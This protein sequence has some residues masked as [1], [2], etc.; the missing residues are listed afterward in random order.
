VL[1]IEGGQA[2]RGYVNGQLPG[3]PV[4][5]GA[6]PADVNS[7]GIRVLTQNPRYS[8][9]RSQAEAPAAHNGWN[10]T[11]YVFEPKSARELIVTQL[12]DPQSSWKKVV[13]R[14]GNR[15][16]SAVVIEWEAVAQ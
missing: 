7:A 11:E 8:N 9:G 16:V 12:P 13:V 4:R 14:A 10:R 6:Y 5:I 1:T 15:R 3:I 2:S